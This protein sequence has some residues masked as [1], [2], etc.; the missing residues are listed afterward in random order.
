MQNEKIICLQAAIFYIIIIKSGYSLME[1]HLT[2]KEIA[3][4]RGY[5]FDSGWLDSFL[6]F[7]I[8][9]ENYR[10]LKIYNQLCTQRIIITSNSYSWPI[11]YYI[12][13]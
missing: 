6:H 13:K 9:S 1:E 5:R 8:S 2:V 12:R 3:E 10:I 11:Y 7:I 4:I